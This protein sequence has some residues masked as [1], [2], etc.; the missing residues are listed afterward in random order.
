MIQPALIELGPPRL[1]DTTLGL[2]EK[3][4]LVPAVGAERETLLYSVYD[5]A[6][7]C[8]P[9][10]SIF[11]DYS[12]GLRKAIWT[13]ADNCV[14][15]NYWTATYL[16]SDT[17]LAQLRENYQVAICPGTWGRNVVTRTDESGHRH[18]SREGGYVLVKIPEDSDPLVKWV[19]LGHDP[20]SHFYALSDKSGSGRALKHILE[21]PGG[22]HGNIESLSDSSVVLSD[23]Q[24]EVSGFGPDGNHIRI[25]YSPVFTRPQI[26][27]ILRQSYALPYFRVALSNDDYA[28]WLDG[29]CGYEVDCDKRE[30]A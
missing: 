6:T 7:G 13:M 2:G 15:A 30:T 29:H 23:S 12:E 11:D 16:Y 1:K 19:L 22:C 9:G 24:F 3:G 14:H 10:I 28:S 21:N 27:E 4:D 18:V 26:R 20:A 8:C 5:L 17:E 25:A